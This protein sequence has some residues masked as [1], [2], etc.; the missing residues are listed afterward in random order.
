LVACLAADGAT[1][2]ARALVLSSE[3]APAL[4]ELDGKNTRYVTNTA[5]IRLDSKAKLRIDRSGR[6]TGYVATYSHRVGTRVYTVSSAAQLMRSATGAAIWLS[7]D[8]VQE[9]AFNRQRRRA[10]ARPYQRQSLSIGAGGWMYWATEPLFT[11][12]EWRVGRAVGALMTWGLTRERT[13]A[14]ARSQ[15]RSMRA[16]LG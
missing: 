6:V 4:F 16:A 13:I 14:L 5:A 10:N 12:V 3:D 7:D 8:D 9:R 1:V 15:A 2:D 11:R